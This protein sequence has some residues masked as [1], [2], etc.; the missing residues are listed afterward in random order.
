MR[1][2][3]IAVLFLFGFLLPAE[4]GLVSN[5]GPYWIE[6]LGEDGVL[7]TFS[8]GGETYVLGTQGERYEIQ[9]VNRSGARIEA[10]VSVD[11]RDVI[12]GQPAD[13]RTKRGYIVPAW[14]MLSI[15][16]FRLNQAQAAAFRFSDVPSS[17][18]ARM[19][20][21]RNVG[22]VGVAIFCER[23]RPEPWPARGFADQLEAPAPPR[24][25]ELRERSSGP[26]DQAESGTA[27][28]LAAPQRP[29]LQPH[30]GTEFGEQRYSPIRWVSFERQDSTNPQVILGLRYND[31]AGL[32]AAG[33]RIPPEPLPG[34]WLSADPFPNRFATPP[35]GWRR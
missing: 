6:I 22:V 33:I 21:P 15:D 16:G 26:E 29:T 5:S 3:W 13:Y 32:I 9:I 12:D 28:A 11:G 35:P 1:K 4:A 34:P 30:L 18:A 8:H 10:V 24:S 17:Y 31:R 20:D 2:S 7:P 19:G 27:S 25:G 14:G 23:R